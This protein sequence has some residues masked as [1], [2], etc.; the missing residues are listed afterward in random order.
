MAYDKIRL[1]VIG[2]GPSNMASTLALLENEPD[3]RY[4]ITAACARRIAVRCAWPQRPQRCI[5]PPTPASRASTAA[6]GTGPMR[7][8]R[9]P[10]R[11]IDAVQ[12]PWR[13]CSQT[14]M[15]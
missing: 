4:Q 5:R 3:L 13:N 1:G 14:L 2:M 8:R 9:N 7:A 11:E 12:P 6:C 10:R 15:K